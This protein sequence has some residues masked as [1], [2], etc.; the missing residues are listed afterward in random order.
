MKEKSFTPNTTIEKTDEGTLLHFCFQ[1]E[2]EYQN[3]VVDTQP[4]FENIQETVIGE[5]KKA[6]R[7]VRVAMAW[8]TNYAIFK[9]VKEILRKGVEVEIIINNDLINNGGY[10]LNLDEL[11]DKGLQLRLAEYP[12]F[13]HNK[14]CVIDDEVVI[15]GSYNWTIF[16]EHLNDEDIVITRGSKVMV[17]KYNERFDVLCEKYGSPVCSMP[18]KVPERPEYDRSSFRTYI[19]EESLFLSS[20]DDSGEKKKRGYLKMAKKLS[21]LHPGVASFTREEAFS[22]TIT[23]IDSNIQKAD[24]RIQTSQKRIEDLRQKLE[25]SDK[26]ERLKLRDKIKS[27]QREIVELKSQKKE[28]VQQK[29]FIKQ[30]EDT[31][32]QGMSG[33]FRINLIWD[34]I[35]DIDLHFVLPNGKDIHYGNIK[36]TYNGYT[37]ELDKDENVSSP[38]TNTPQENIYWKDGL[39]FGEYAINVSLYTFRSNLSSINCRITVEDELFGTKILSLAIDTNKYKDGSNFTV[40]RFSYTENGRIER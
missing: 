3:F 26:D 39:P 14:F 36:E 5:L 11:I 18:E 24:K 25:Y 27:H 35:D 40:Y 21:P 1:P 17:D 15:T 13:I 10:C 12:R 31:I 4:V 20:L 23:T 8:F 32:L 7:S 29:K 16:S 38:Y 34:T 22:E 9:V 37:G 33:K 6:T 30:T 19:T 2:N 28:Y